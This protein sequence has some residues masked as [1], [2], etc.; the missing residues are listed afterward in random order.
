MYVEYRPTIRLEER[1]LALLKEV[2]EKRQISL[3]DVVRESIEELV[4]REERALKIDQIADRL[5]DE[6]A[7]LFNELAKR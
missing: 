1:T 6:H 7:W 4:A 5:L 2:A 3:D